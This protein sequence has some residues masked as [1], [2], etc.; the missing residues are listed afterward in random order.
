MSFQKYQKYR[1]ATGRPRNNVPTISIYQSANSLLAYMNA[2]AVEKFDLAIGKRIFVY[3]DSKTR[4]AAIKVT[5]DW[6][7]FALCGSKMK[8][9]V[10]VCLTGFYNFFNIKYDGKR[11]YELRDEG[12]MITFG[13]LDDARAG[14]R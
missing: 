9:E 13:P 7:G 2:A 1:S 6:N 10:R 12:D 11:A 5:D 4:I 14:A 8:N 3:F